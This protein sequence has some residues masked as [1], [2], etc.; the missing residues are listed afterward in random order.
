MPSPNDCPPFVKICQIICISKCGRTTKQNYSGKEQLQQQKRLTDGFT[1]SIK[2]RVRPVNMM[3][4]HFAMEEPRKL[5]ELF[6]YH[7]DCGCGCGWGLLHCL[8]GKF[9]C[10][11]CNVVFV[12]VLST[13]FKQNTP[14]DRI[15][16]H[17]IIGHV[18]CMSAC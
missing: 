13:F 5:H 15:M 10:C 16:L 12:F 4:Q 2:A 8:T 18:F 7:G 9:H 1:I 11:C 3:T 6:E 14:A 17:P